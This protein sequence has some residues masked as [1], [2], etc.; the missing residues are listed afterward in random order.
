[1]LEWLFGDG[2]DTGQASTE[3]EE[4]KPTIRFEVLSSDEKF[5]DYARTLSDMSPLDACYNIVIYHL[6]KKC[7]ELTEEELGKLSVQLLNC[8]S[9]AENRQVYSCTS[10]MTLAECTQSM[11][12]TT[13]NSYQIVGNR[14]RA[15][16]YATQQVQF[17]RLTEVTVNQLVSAA[18]DQIK[19]LT[20]IKSGQEQL[21]SLTSETVRKLYESQQDLLST[22]HA[23]RAAHDDVFKHIAVNVQ[24]ILHE[25][26]LIAS[27]NK[28]LAALT[29]NIKDKLDSTARQIKER[30][31]VEHKKHER[32]L[33]DLKD[34]QDSAE[35][36]VK[37][38]E[39]NLEKLLRKCEQLDSLYFGMSANLSKMNGTINH[40]MSELS[41]LGEHLD[42]KISW[43]TQLLG[44][45]D[46]KLAD[47]SCCLLHIAYFFLLVVTATFLEISLPFR[48]A[49]LVIIVGNVAA[50]L[51]YQNSLDFAGLT[52]FLLSIYFGFK[53]LI[54]IGLKFNTIPRTAYQS[55][56]AIT[57]SRS[58]HPELLPPHEMRLLI[59]LL[60]RVSETTSQ[61]SPPSPVVTHNGSVL[62]DTSFRPSTPPRSRSEVSDQLDNS[63]LQDVGSF[64]R[65]LIGHLGLS[66]RNS[67]RS[68]T[69]LA[70]ESRSS[71]P[72]ISSR[73][74]SNTVAGSQCR[75]PAA[76]GSDFCRRHNQN[77]R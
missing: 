71:T 16:C 32:I 48:L 11:D 6:K 46:N 24:E 21:Q 41:T 64:R 58:S 18:S 13:W 54:Y 34:I 56:N 68:S 30:E 27:G 26:A 43:I 72:S 52:V 75:L 51:N 25:K 2:K 76:P 20:D 62:H 17:R 40:V 77:Q 57:L 7:G 29:E 33:Q 8:Q 74:L 15:M 36:S 23:L 9:E 4:I 55:Q 73:C 50:E 1:M 3:T 19:T 31:E 37:K 70:N 66:S 63:I 53:L 22:Q 10:S 47:M 67:S 49:M 65:T 59:D 69:P 14:A 35:A 61:H 38:L 45:A 39:L 60:K 44:G 12:G 5:L 28:E 42:E